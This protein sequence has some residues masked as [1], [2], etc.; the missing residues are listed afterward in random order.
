FTTN[1]RGLG[2]DRPDK[3]HHGPTS[4]LASEKTYGHSGFTGTAVWVDPVQEIVY[5]FISNRVNPDASNNR[6]NRDN[7]RP[8]IQ[9]L[10]Y[11]S[12]LNYKAPF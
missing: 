8:F 7:I 6:L 10:V 5:V 11:K 3:G 2:W 9:T 12:I 1:R 4:Y